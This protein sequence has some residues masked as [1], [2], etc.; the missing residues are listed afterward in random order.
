LSAFGSF[1]AAVAEVA[2]DENGEVRVQ[3]LTCA[4]DC[5]LLVNPDTV[6]AQ[7]QGGMIFGLTATLYGAITLEGGRVQQ[8]NFNDYRMLRIDQTPDID[9]HLVIS[10]EAPGGIGEP[11][12]AIVQPAV[13]NAI[14][15]ATGVHLTRM[16]IDRRLL[17]TR[18]A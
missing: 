8:A 14:Y 5:G 18:P 4:V 12:T 9:V 2:V 13:A 15:A 10:D 11:G 17:A 7:I 16:P 6:V 1:L 3:R